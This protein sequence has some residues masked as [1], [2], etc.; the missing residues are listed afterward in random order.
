MLTKNKGELKG[1]KKQ[2]FD[3]DKFDPNERPESNEDSSTNA[4]NDDGD[5]DITP[6]IFAFT[7]S[8]T[9]SPLLS[10]SSLPTGSG[11]ETG[12]EGSGAICQGLEL[13]GPVP[14]KVHQHEDII[15]LKNVQ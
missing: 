14:F 3:E 5:G 1:K 10:E 11:M 4:P 7:D 8:E 2:K 12:S 13:I 15:G 9:S 6:R